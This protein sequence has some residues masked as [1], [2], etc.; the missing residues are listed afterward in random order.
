MQRYI[1]LLLL[2]ITIIAALYYLLGLALL[3]LQCTLC[4]IRG[5]YIVVNITIIVYY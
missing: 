5:G 1:I 2:R 4:T 3:H